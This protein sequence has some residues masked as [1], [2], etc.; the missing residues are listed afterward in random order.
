M[1]PL[2]EAKDRDGPKRH[3]EERGQAIAY[4]T[5]SDAGEV[6]IE[7]RTKHFKHYRLG[8]FLRLE[9]KTPVYHADLSYRHEKTE[10]HHMKKVA[11]HARGVDFGEL[12]S[13]TPMTRTGGGW[14]LDGSR[15][16]SIAVPHSA[17]P[18]DC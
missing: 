15:K 1:G 17:A 5:R 11:V 8:L 4:G 13:P 3:L 12:D 2:T 18:R 7:I 14:R 16:I 6:S 10:F 9:V